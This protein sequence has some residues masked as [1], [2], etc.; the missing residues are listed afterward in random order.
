MDLRGQSG[1]EFHTI[2]QLSLPQ[3]QYVDWHRL[4]QVDIRLVLIFR[5]DPESPEWLLCGFQF[6]KKRLPVPMT[7]EQSAYTN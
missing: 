6:P 5:L 3:E 1:A 2:Q 7:Q 4:Q